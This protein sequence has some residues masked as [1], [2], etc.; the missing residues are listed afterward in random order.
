MAEEFEVTLESGAVGKNARYT[1]PTMGLRWMDG[2]LQ[3]AWLVTQCG[4]MNQPL[5]RH[6]KWR[7]VPDETGIHDDHSTPSTSP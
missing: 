2:K 6:I 3:Q 5:E 7:D 4:E 1:R